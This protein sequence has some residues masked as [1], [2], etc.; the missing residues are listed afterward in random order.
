MTRHP[1]TLAAIAIFFCSACEIRQA[2]DQQAETAPV[3]EPTAEPPVATPPRESIIRNSVRAEADVP[4]EP[5]IKPVSITLAYAEADGEVPESALAQVES[6]LARPALAEGGCILVTGHTDS[7]GSDAQ[8][9]K[10]SKR[11]AS[12]IAALLVE[13]GVEEQRIRTIAMGERRPV[14]PNA[15]PDGSDDP[16]GRGRNR[17]V[18]ID[19]Q[20]PGEDGSS[21]CAQASGQAGGQAVE[22][23]R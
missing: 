18:T 23:S 4:A 1:R 22:K 2:P 13:K 17:R 9:I 7:R 20:L 14:A 3:A 12:Q 5:P 10:V 16:E 19:V 21:G 6:L 15:R 11:R 8:N